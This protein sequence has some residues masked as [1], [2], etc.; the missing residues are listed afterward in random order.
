MNQE[1]IGLFIAK[2]RKDKNLT[3]EELAEKIGV[4]SKSVSRW[5]NGKT[6]PDYSILKSLCSLLEV[7]VNELLAGEKI[8]REEILTYSNDNIDLILKEYY[9]MKKHK[10]IIKNILIVISILFLLFVRE[11][12]MGLG[13]VTLTSLDPIKNI[14]GIENYDKN[15]YIKEY[16]SDLD[17]NLSIFPENKSDI[18]EVTFSSSFQTNLFD[19][20]GYILLT[21]K[22]KKEE[23]D[24]EINR[25][26][27]LSM[28]IYDSC[29]DNAQSYTNYVK[30]DDKSYEY[31]AYITIDGFG[32]TYEYALVN[33]EG[34]EIIY[35]YLAYPNKE[36]SRYKKY[37]KKDLSLYSITNTLEMY[38]MYNH[39]FDN[40][41]SFM[42]FG[43]CN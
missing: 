38:S 39:S 40:G 41:E 11:V 43:D 28:T 30:Y 35:I 27:K 20:N 24:S 37:L 19:S 32:H 14:S 5:E 33:E 4:T 31:P 7:D 34:L 8:K 3:Q 29:K 21:S 1:K 42:E 13:L 12:I 6:M 26:R 2:C 25:L 15:Y 9:K 18:I 10:N 16:G 22:Y 36:D 23:F 17:S